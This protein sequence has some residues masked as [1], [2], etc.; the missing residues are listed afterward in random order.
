MFCVINVVRNC[1]D[2]HGALSKMRG[3]GIRLIE[4]VSEFFGHWIHI[5]LRCNLYLRVYYISNFL[6]QLAYYCGSTAVVALLAGTKL[7]VANIGDSRCLIGSADKVVIPMTSD[8]TPLRPREADRI[9]KAGGHVSV[10]GRVNHDINMSR[11][12]G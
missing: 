10:S 6:F 9:R 4:I 8:H 5:C 2:F 11:A 3:N 1:A 7:F 12:F